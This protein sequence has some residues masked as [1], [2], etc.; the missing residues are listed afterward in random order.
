MPRPSQ[1]IDDALL[2]SGRELYPRLGSSGLSLRA[3][4]EHA[5]AN[6]GMFHYHFKTKDNF[7]RTLLQQLY[8][9]DVLGAR[10]SRRAMKG[11]RSSGCAG[12]C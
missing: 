12:R 7:L 2:A 8:E 9:R 1:R 6:L 5:G 11:R 4:T 3:L 10:A